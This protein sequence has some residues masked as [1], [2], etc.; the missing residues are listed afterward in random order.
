[1]TEERQRYLVKR[2]RKGNLTL[3]ELT[4]VERSWLNVQVLRHGLLP[5]AYYPLYETDETE[6]IFRQKAEKKRQKRQEKLKDTVIT[7][8][9][10]FL[11]F[12]LGRLCGHLLFL[13]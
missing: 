10:A 4:D 5:I 8:S 6:P 9:L 2:H 12:L 7:L 1:M 3:N 11:C 13:Q